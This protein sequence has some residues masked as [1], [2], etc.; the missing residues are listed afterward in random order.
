MRKGCGPEKARDVTALGHW[1][2]ASDREIG[3]A[4]P[5]AQRRDRVV[6]RQVL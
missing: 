2:H 3:C 5:A 4:V 6:P 1:L